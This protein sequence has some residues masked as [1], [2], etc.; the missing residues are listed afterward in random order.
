[1][2]LGMAQAS[3]D[4][5][6]RGR[7]RGAVMA[8]CAE[9]GHAE[10][11]HAATATSPGCMPFER[12][13]RRRLR[14]QR[15]RQMRARCPPAARRRARSLSGTFRTTRLKGGS[16]RKVKRPSCH[17]PPPC[18]RPSRAFRAAYPSAC[19]LAA[20]PLAVRSPVGQR[21]DAAATWPQP[22][23]QPGPIA[24]KCPPIATRTL[25]SAGGGSRVAARQQLH[26]VPG[27]WLMQVAACCSH[28]W[29]GR[30]F[31]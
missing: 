17:A 30:P 27:I 28:C 9:L 11:G 31:L 3:R 4:C 20:R 22:G 14:S 21:G 1:M 10:L 7:R 24:H 16:R 13:Q 29:A 25:T 26:L 5:G 18:P 6:P 15:C 12:P 2:R 8:C 23:P 19:P